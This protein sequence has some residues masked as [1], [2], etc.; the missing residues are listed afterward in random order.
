MNA[1]DFAALLP[2]IVLAATS[3]I[4][5]LVIAFH[6]SHRAAAFMTLAGML[7]A[8]VT[9]FRAAAVE[10]CRVTALI[11][12][13][14]Y[15]LFYMGL[16]I[17]ASF[18][19]AVLAYDY[20]R[21]RDGVNEEFYLLLLLATTG[22][23][24]LAASS[25]FVSLFLGLEM[26]SVS[27][28]AM[29]AYQRGK[30]RGD[31]AG[32]KYLVL[33]ATA[34]SFILFGMAVVY[35][36]AGA[37]ELVQIARTAAGMKDGAVFITGLVMIIVGIAFKLALAPFHMWTP[38][39]Y[40]GAPAPV[41]AFIATVSKG[42]VFALLL[43][44]FIV[45]NIHD[46]PVLVGLFAALAVASML[47][48][49]ILALFQRNVKRLLAYS[50]IAH[51]GYALVAALAGGALSA[52]AVSYYLVAYFVTILGAFGIVSVVSK[53]GEGEEEA[54]MLEDYQGLA[55]RRP[56]LAGGFTALL[57][58][59]AGIPLTAGFI[60]KFYV[61][62][63]GARSALWTLLIVL[64]VSSAIGLYYYLRVIAA[65]YARVPEERGYAGI[66]PF[67]SFT[68]GVVLAVLIAALIVL[69]IYPSPLI[70]LL[71]TTVA[72]LM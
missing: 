22:A 30:E 60:G 66:L 64:A 50:S 59:L 7:I 31:E 38:D 47:I 28:Y 46:A 34:S 2:I 54:E 55:W 52:T 19:T 20:F 8:F 57:L 53:G 1:A 15:A 67:I 10:P 51:L 48:G 33:A 40:E 37:M 13:D 12:V 65:L 27:L 49:N 14:A 41:S 26:L 71:Q 23:A 68:G 39:V 29:I 24:V 5:M 69:G 17:A 43:R 3:V 9:I 18:V 36:R 21:R 25:H 45:M 62:A 35:A 58:S 70:A 44:S 72:R 56:W 42:A 11:V 16:L 63:A 32:L 4:V 61:I 6:R